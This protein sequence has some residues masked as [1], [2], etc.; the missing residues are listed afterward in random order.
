MKNLGFLLF[1]LVAV[2]IAFSGKDAP[3]GQSGTAGPPV[4][5]AASGG[6]VTAPAG[7]SRFTPEGITLTRDGSGQ[8]HL[9]LA[10]NGAQTRF[11]VDTG[12]DLVALT[13]ADA[14]RAGIAVDPAAYKPI[15]RTASGAGLAMPVKLARL[16]LGQAELHDVDAVVVRDLDTSLLGQSV[17][18]R[19]GRVELRGDTMVLEA[20]H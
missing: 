9:D 16:E 10:V 7:A 15:L 13:E 3:F 1:G 8:F 4:A 11:L 6:A 19:I 17:L 14:Q 18:G 20:S 2:G 12:A 5:A